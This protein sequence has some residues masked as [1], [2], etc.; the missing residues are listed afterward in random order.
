MFCLIEQ[1]SCYFILSIYK[2][3]SYFLGGIKQSNL[4]R[5]R[6]VIIWDNFLSI[7]LLFIF[8]FLI[9]CVTFLAK[10]DSLYF[11]GLFQT[12]MACSNDEK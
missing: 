2:L 1:N 12:L 3:K 6:S 10:T 9:A 5:R 4:I 7:F 8:P 11:F